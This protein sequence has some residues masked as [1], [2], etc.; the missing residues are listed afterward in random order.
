MPKKRTP[1]AERQQETETESHSSRWLSRI[2]GRIPGLV[3]GRESVLTCGRWAFVDELLDPL[4]PKD[5]LDTN[6]ERTRR[7][8][9]RLGRCGLACL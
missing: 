9:L 1:V 7:P 6:G 4:E 3:P 2:T 5:K 8:P